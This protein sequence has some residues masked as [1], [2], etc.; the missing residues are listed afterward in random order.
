MANDSSKVLKNRDT[1]LLVDAAKPVGKQRNGASPF[2]SGPD[3]SAHTPLET[4]WETALGDFAEP[5]RSGWRAVTLPHNWED[6]HGYARESHGNLHGTAWYRLKWTLPEVGPDRELF[7]FFEG[8]GSYA[9]VW[10]N[11]CHVG[12]HAGG[13]TT[14]TVRLTHALKTGVR[15]DLLV[16]AHHPEKID[17]LPFVCGGCWGAP[18][19]EGSQ[20][21]GIFRPV[22][23]YTTGTAWLAPFGLYAWTDTLAAGRARI[24]AR[25]EV[26]TFGPG[27]A[28]APRF[29]WRLTNA[30]DREVA[31]GELAWSP[32]GE[33]EHTEWS[34]DVEDP[35]LW[36]AEDPHLYT[37]SARLVGKTGKLLSTDSVPLGIRRFHWP[38][39]A[40]PNEP[41]DVRSPSR[42]G[43]L[44][45]DGRAPV[46]AGNNGFTRETFRHPEC[47]LGAMEAESVILRRVTAD[48]NN[49]ILGCSIRAAHTAAAPVPLSLWGEVCN[50]AGTVFHHHFS[51]TTEAQPGKEIRLDW[52]SGNLAFPRYWKPGEH[53]VHRITIEWTR[54]VD[55]ELMLRTE[56]TFGFQDTDEPLNLAPPVYETTAA[57]EPEDSPDGVLRWND[58]PFFIN[59]TGEYETRLGQDHAFEAAEVRARVAQIRAA[60]FNAFRDAHHPHNLRYYRELDAAGLPCWTQM[61]SNIYFDTDA[62]RENYRCLLIEW[63]R[64]RRAHPCVFLWGLQN[65]SALPDAFARAM[66]GVIAELDPST[67]RDR[68]VT[69]CNG[70]TGSHWN[71]PQEWSGTYGGNCADYNLRALQMVGEYGAWR[72][73]GVH[74]DVD[75]EGDE[76][77]RSESWACHAME[78]KIRLA[79]AHRDKAVGHWHWIFNSF[80]NPGRSPQVTEGPGNHAIGPVNN[81]GLVTAWGQ[82]SDLF[83]LFRANYCDASAA[84]MV[85]IVSPTWPDRWKGPGRY[86]NI[87]VYS[88]CDEVELYNDIG[89]RSLGVRQHPGRGRHFRWDDVSIRKNVLYAEGRVNGRVVARHTVVLRNLS[90]APGLAAFRADNA[91]LHLPLKSEC[92]LRVNC[93]AREAHTDAY[94][95]VWAADAPT[96]PGRTGWHSWAEA[97]P[98][99]DSD[100]ASVGAF[101]HPVA[102]AGPDQALWQSYRYGRH[103]LAY[104]LTAS[105]GRYRIQ[106]FTTEPWYGEG[107]GMDCAGWRLFDIAVNGRTL[108]RDVDVWK[109]VGAFSAHRLDL[110]TDHQGGSLRI[111]FPRTAA[112]QALVCAIAVYRM[113]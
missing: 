83:H 94:G 48:R 13:R 80:P 63:V 71:V 46:D 49:F 105:A 102:G 2:A 110:D 14:F 45:D 16:R 74:R 8:V 73:F 34:F 38:Q 65:E 90:E 41:K 36:S 22:S 52:K 10:L 58:R 79:E 89:D 31:G 106:I 39:I 62:F 70:G 53:A 42:R 43:R 95:Q 3:P 20:P 77:D 84:P 60:G 17:D 111:H 101:T 86:G 82:P 51:D 91:R 7:L 56:T 61:G 99:L 85:Y 55:G 30:R 98:R 23:A 69:T 33:R 97:N 57:A 112:A 113:G 96:A 75:Y 29:I 11:G 35:V 12:S 18:Y 68:L 67:G 59:G 28:A 40:R 50:E 25:F 92:V 6:Y 9:D 19:S 21:F 93:G 109:A 64:E 44:I 72:Q 37:L 24:C 76:N 32:L 66:T 54:P 4:G 1:A 100:L 78:T 15:Q 88:N 26:K 107:G 27:G 103:R 108:A 5:P 47:P 87:R 104:S 81:K